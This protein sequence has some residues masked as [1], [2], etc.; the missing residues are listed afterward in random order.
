MTPVLIKKARI[1][2]S[3][4]ILHTLKHQ[5]CEQGKALTASPAGCRGA[6]LPV[7]KCSSGLEASHSKT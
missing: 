4:A 5:G 7:Y 2:T 1:V 3:S 6:P